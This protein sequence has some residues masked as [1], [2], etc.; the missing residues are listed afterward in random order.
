MT[1][2]ERQTL[3]KLPMKELALRL[4]LAEAVIMSGISENASE[5]KLKEV[6]RQRDVIK[7]AIK[8]KRVLPEGPKPKGIIVKM[9][10]ASLRM[11]SKGYE[12]RK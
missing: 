1:E 6:A 3:L 12:R 9:K 7:Q 10:P 4:D 11:I 5:S 2:H 8:D